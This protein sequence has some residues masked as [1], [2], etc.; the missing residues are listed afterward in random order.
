MKNHPIKNVQQLLR[1]ADWAEIWVAML[2]WYPDQAESEAKYKRVWWRL[3][4]LPDIRTSANNSLYL[5]FFPAEDSEPAYWHINRRINGEIY[6][7]SFAPWRSMVSLNTSELPEL[8]IAE[9]AAHVLWEMTFFG[10]SD[11]AVEAEADKVFGRI[12]K[13][14]V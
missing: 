10:W 11:V 12:K 5:K 1:K 14:K 13:I 7:C 4:K 3:I 9:I 8:P 2:K 6:S